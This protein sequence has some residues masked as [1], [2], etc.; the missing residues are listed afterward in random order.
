ML[1]KKWVKKI[2]FNIIQQMRVYLYDING[3]QLQALGVTE[4]SSKDFRTVLSFNRESD[5]LKAFI[6]SNIALGNNLAD[7]CWR[8]NDWINDRNSGYRR[9]E[10]IHGHNDFGYGLES[11]SHIKNVWSQLKSVI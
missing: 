5:T 11:T 4:N 8:G 10:Q 9:Y 1:L 3:R 6:T 2:I 7:D